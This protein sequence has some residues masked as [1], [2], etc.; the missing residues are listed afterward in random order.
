MS[1]LRAYLGLAGYYRRYVPSF[2]IIAAP[3]FE[4]TRKNRKFVWTSAQQRAFEELKNRLI[5]P[6]ILG[7]PTPNGVFCVSVDASG[8][9]LGVV[10]EQSQDGCDRVIAYASRTLTP[11]ERNYSTTKR[12]LL[13]VIFALK[14]FRHYLLGRHFIL[15]TDHASL[16]WLRTTPEPISQAARWLALIEEYDFE[17]QHRPGSKHQNADSLSRRPCR[18]CGRDEIKSKEVSKPDGEKQ[19]CVCACRAGQASDPDYRPRGASGP[20][21]PEDEPINDKPVW[22]VRSPAELAELQKNCPDVSFITHLRLESDEQPPFD[23]IRGQSENTNMYWSQWSQLVVYKGVVY[24]VM[25]DPKG[26]PSGRQ[27]LT[28]V[29]LREE[30]IECVHEGLTG[31]HIGL[32]RTTLQVRR[33][34]YWRG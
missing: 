29:A 34:A 30:L 22:H 20:P 5:S 15:K 18:Q 21:P 28:P 25:F 8:T 9:G 31:S 10:L 33:R 14:K 12:E 26:Q 24:R 13:S 23:V 19:A 17:I 27:L 6:P 16:Q 32:A 11:S 7:A 1:E 3:L 2:S 4:L